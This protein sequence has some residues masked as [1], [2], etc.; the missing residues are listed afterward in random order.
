MV[1]EIEQDTLE[2]RVLRV[3]LE[4]Y[5]VTLKDLRWELKISEGRLDR[6][7]KKLISRGVIE[8]EELPGTTYVR[9]L[10]TDL[11][12]VGMKPSQ[13]KRFKRKGGKKEGED[14]EGI[15]FQ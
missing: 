9:L 14:Y 8:V 4:S 6:V 10:R 13:K 5:P 1:V 2:E 7:L 11:V 3:L 15:M 12:F